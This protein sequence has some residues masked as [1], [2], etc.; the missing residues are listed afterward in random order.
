MSFNQVMQ[1]SNLAKVTSNIEWTKF[2]THGANMHTTKQL[3]MEAP[4]ET[5][6]HEV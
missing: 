6:I 3:P 1:V 5:I 4:K 2:E